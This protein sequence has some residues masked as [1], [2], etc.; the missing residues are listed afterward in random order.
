MNDADKTKIIRL[1]QLDEFRSQLVALLYTK[2]SS[3]IPKTD[4]A[5]AVQTSLGLADSAL[6]ASDIS[7]LQS[8]VAALQALVSEGEN[9]T[10][11]ID[12][13]N[14]IVAFLANIQNTQTLDGIVS[15]IN[16]SIGAKYTKPSTG[17][18]ATDLAQAVQTSLGLADSAL[19]SH[20]DISGKAEKSEMSVVAGTGNDADKTTITLKTGTSATVLT[21]HQDISGKAEKSE[22][23][24]VAGTGNDA[25]K[26]TI[27]LKTGTS[28][29][30]LTAHQDISGKVDKVAGK[31]LSANDYS[32][33]DKAKVDALTYATT[34]DIQALFA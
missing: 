22:M 33:T 17:I 21:A 9:P 1:E 4:L 2:P 19:Q 31:G 6:Q 30:V 28:A 14:E 18:P 16:T 25:D 29:T 3:G 23:S 32:D 20:Q 10:A 15:G 27:T 7:Q 34:S 8:D 24:V 26:T 11:A 5:Q 13:F 12:K